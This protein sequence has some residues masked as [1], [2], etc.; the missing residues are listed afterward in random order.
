[1]GHFE[2]ESMSEKLLDMNYVNKQNKWTMVNRKKSNKI[3]NSSWV[4][5]AAKEK[6]RESEHSL[7]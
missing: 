1:M 4:P 5:Y 2:I 7:P 3:T 6:K